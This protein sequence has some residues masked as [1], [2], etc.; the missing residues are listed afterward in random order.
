MMDIN[1]DERVPNR[2]IRLVLSCVPSSPEHC[3][4]ALAEPA[5]VSLVTHSHMTPE[6]LVIWW[7]WGMSSTPCGAGYTAAEP[8][9]RHGG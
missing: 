3:L 2:A 5:C 1:R 8:A 7:P 9:Q 4:V 6:S